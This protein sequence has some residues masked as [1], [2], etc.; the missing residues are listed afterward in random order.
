M[1]KKPRYLMP[2]YTDRTDVAKLRGLREADI[3]YSDI[4]PLDDPAWTKGAAKPAPRKAA[5][6]APAG[7]RRKA[8]GR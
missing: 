6:G 2:D 4:P 7:R 8:A 5:S 1:G 3:D